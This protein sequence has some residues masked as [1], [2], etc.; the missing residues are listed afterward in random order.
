MSRQAWVEPAP[1]QKQTAR[2]ACRR[3]PPRK[4][5]DPWRVGFS[6]ARNRGGCCSVRKDLHVRVDVSSG[7]NVFA[8]VSALITHASAYRA[9][10]PPQWQSRSPTGTTRC[11]AYIHGRQG[12]ACD[13]VVLTRHAQGLRVVDACWLDRRRR[14]GRVRV[15]AWGMDRRVGAK[16]QQSVTTFRSAQ[17]WNCSRKKR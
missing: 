2:T 9:I 3:R 5:E 1:A 17:L 12:F 15:D 8:P 7:S 13:R 10:G 4:A 11:N 16:C 14:L 6:C